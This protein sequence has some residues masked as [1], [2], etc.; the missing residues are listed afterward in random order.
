MLA[1]T[2][3]R[4]T[5]S[6]ETA[7]TEGRPTVRLWDGRGLKILKPR[8]LFRDVL[9]EIKTDNVATTRSRLH[10]GTSICP[11]L[12]IYKRS[13]VWCGALHCNNERRG[14]VDNTSASYSGCPWF[15]SRPGNSLSWLRLFMVFFSPSRQILGL[16]LKLGHDH[17]LIHPFQFI[18][19]LSPIHY[20][21]YILNHW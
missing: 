21:L 3:R 2:R 10:N 5:R 18:I 6:F 1:I 13:L 9:V 8:K 16:Y 17:F 20:T 19:H 4:G 14:R 7:E 12:T 11:K 15:K